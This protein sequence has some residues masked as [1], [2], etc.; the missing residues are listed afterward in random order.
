MLLTD[1]RDDAVPD[2][3]EV[4]AQRLE[5]A[6]RGALITKADDPQQ[7]VLGPDMTVAEP[8]RFVDREIDDLPCFGRQLDLTRGAAGTRTVRFDRP[9]E[10][11]TKPRWC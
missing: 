4:E 11:D 1:L 3:L 9:T 7:Q 8:A 6:G 10:W 2:R 5:R